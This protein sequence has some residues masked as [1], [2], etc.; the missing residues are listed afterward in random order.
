MLEQNSTPGSAST[1]VALAAAVPALAGGSPRAAAVVGMLIAFMGGYLL[2]ALAHRLPAQEGV[3]EAAAASRVQVPVG[4]SPGQGPDDALVTVVEFADFECGYCARSVALQKRLLA[5]FPGTVRWVFKQFPL[6][7]HANARAAARAALAAHAQSRFWPYHD[8]LFA[9]RQRL[10]QGRLVE[11]AREVGLDMAR[12]RSDLDG[13]ATERLVKEDLELGRK[14]GV[15]GTPT[16][17]INGRK[18][19]GSMGYANLARMV[20]EELAWAAELLRRGV[21]RAQIYEELTRPAP[22]PSQPASRPASGVSPSAGYR[23]PPAW[24]GRGVA[25]AQG[26]GRPG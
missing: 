5:E 6:D 10:T 1:S 9:D 26:R 13:P 23:G 15:P 7:F 20:R 4:L 14:V 11:I 22:P 21:P 12:F 8:R 16:F 2:G 24:P 18:V 25:A 17:F 3:K 19:E